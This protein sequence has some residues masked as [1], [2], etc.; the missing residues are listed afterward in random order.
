MPSK[1]QYKYTKESFQNKLN[2][3]TT[4]I[5]VIGEYC[6]SHSTIMVQC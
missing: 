4:A 1:Q 3:L 5:D 6:G 2:Q